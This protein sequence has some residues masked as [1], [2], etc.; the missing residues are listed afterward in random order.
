[1]DNY[2]SKY[3][4]L[5]EKILDG[6]DTSDRAAVEAGYGRLREANE[7]MLAGNPRFAETGRDHAMRVSVESVI[8][9]H[10]AA[11]ESAADTAAQNEGGDLTPAPAAAK[12]APAVPVLTFVVGLVVGAAMIGGLAFAGIIGPVASDNAAVSAGP[13]DERGALWEAE[14]QAALPLVEASAELLGKV[15]EEIVKRQRDDSAAVAKL[16]GGKF[17]ALRAFDPKL[18]G[19][20]PKG[21]P[22]GSRVILSADAK[23]YKVLIAGPLCRTVAL[24]RPEL[25]DPKRKGDGLNCTHF[26]RWNEAGAAL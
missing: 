2:T 19:A 9:G 6:V 16:F 14:Y 13:G 7:R 24:A 5:L 12:R 22:R 25:V 15:E 26:G 18:A 1:M 10:A 3:R 23:A 4:T 8:A 11:L 20:I 21:L 17:L